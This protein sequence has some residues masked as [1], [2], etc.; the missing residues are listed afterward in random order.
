MS[1]RRFVMFLICA[2]LSAGALFGASGAAQASAS[3][4]SLTQTGVPQE[5]DIERISMEEFKALLA[6]GAP[7]TIIDVRGPSDSKIKGAI[8]IP[9]YELESRLN[10]IPRD[11]EIVTY[12]A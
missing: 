12:C 1:Y 4:A 7:L 10:E 6:K 11:R 8:S 3:F 2:A 5:A 9:V